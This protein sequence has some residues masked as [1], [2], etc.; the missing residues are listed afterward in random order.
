MTAMR[1]RAARP[2]VRRTVGLVVAGVA[3]C[4]C[5]AAGTA[6][7]PDSAKAEDLAEQ[8]NERLAAVDLPEVDPSTATA[9]YGTDGGVSCKNV[10]GLQQQLA[11]SQFGTNAR[12]QPRLALDPSLVAYDLAV[13]KTYCPDKLDSLI[14][15]IEKLDTE[16]TI[17]TPSD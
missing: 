9:L 10:A 8:L 12:H 3:L 17:P 2:A 15:A 14:D 6:S 1:S 5:T 4:G 11:F 16:D 7:D 13:V